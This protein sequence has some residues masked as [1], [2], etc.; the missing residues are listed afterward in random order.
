MTRKKRTRK[1]Y[2]V[3]RGSPDPLQGIDARRPAGVGRFGCPDVAELHRDLG[4]DGTMVHKILTSMALS[5]KISV[6]SRT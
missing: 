1:A 3:E 2:N 6:N 5:T 4:E